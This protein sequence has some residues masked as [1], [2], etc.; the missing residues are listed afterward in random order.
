MITNETDLPGAAWLQPGGY[1]VM[2]L[3]QETQEKSGNFPL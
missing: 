1:V 2:P 3:T